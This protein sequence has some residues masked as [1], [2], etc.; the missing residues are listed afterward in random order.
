MDFSGNK[1]NGTRISY[2]SL[3]LCTFLIAALG[4]L[5]FGK[6]T[7]ES[8]GL[9]DRNSLQ[10]WMPDTGETHE[11][12]FYVLKERVW[13]IPLLFLFATTHLAKMSGGAFVLWY[14]VSIGLVTGISLLRFGISGLLLV[15]A[16]GI[17]HYLLYVPVFVLVLKL[18]RR[19]R[20]VCRKF[21]IQLFLFEGMV[22]GGCLLESY[23]N[24]IVLKKIITLF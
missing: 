4:V 10:N 2:L 21:F 3:F 24:P 19:Q 12:L 5:L 1:E 8:A 22:L 18:N 15:L 14:G 20:M 16:A 9:L 7:I 6:D 23:I 17:P 13:V 11:L